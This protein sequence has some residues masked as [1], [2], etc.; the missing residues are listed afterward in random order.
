MESFWFW[1][2]ICQKEFSPRNPEMDGGYPHVYPGVVSS[3]ALL[4]DRHSVS[5]DLC[6]LA[7][8]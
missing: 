2:A 6:T 7:P 1:A 4:A 8:A 3:E 5:L